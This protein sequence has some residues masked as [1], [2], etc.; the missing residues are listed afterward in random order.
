MMYYICKVAQSSNRI[1][2]S[3]FVRECNRLGYTKLSNPPSMIARNRLTPRP[4]SFLLTYLGYSYR[5]TFFLRRR[6]SSIEN[7]PDCN[8]NRLMWLKEAE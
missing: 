3:E 4:M 6:L 5:Q 2:A 8:S 1:N 7:D